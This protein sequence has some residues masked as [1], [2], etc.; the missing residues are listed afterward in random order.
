MFIYFYR[1]PDEATPFICE[2]AYSDVCWRRIYCFFLFL[3]VFIGI[4]FFINNT[5]TGYITLLFFLESA[6]VTMCGNRI[7][8]PLTWFRCFMTSSCGINVY[9]IMWIWYNIENSIMEIRNTVR[10]LMDVINQQ[11]TYTCTFSVRFSTWWVMVW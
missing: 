9:V 11:N 2:N 3:E 5:H 8:T 10:S 1:N 7:M 6:I 4:M